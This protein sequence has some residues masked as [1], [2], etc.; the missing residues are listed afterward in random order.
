MLDIKF[1][2][3]NLDAVKA[4][5]VARKVNPE[6]AEE[7][8]GC[9]KALQVSKKEVEHF[10]E[11]RNKIA[12]EMSKG[13]PDDERRRIL[14]EEGKK[15][16]GL[17][18]NLE[19]L[20]AE[21]EEQMKEVL[22]QIPNMALGAPNQSVILRTSGKIP[23]F[24]FE[25]LDHVQLAEKLDLIDFEAGADVVGN[26]FYYLKNDLVF[27]EMA[28]ITYA[29]WKLTEKGFTPIITPDLAKA[30]VVEGIGFNP[31]G[32]NSQIYRTGDLCLIGTSEITLGGMYR[33]K[34]V[35]EAS[36]P[37]KLAGFSHCFRTEAG[38]PGKE[39][40][41]IFRV[42]QFSKVEMFI[43]CRP[44][45]SDKYHQ[46]LLNIEEEIFKDFELPFQVTDIP[47]DDLGAPAA[48]K[49][50]IEAW[51]PGRKDYCEVTSTSNCT[52]FQARR[53]N[54]KCR[55]GKDKARYLHTLNGTAVATSRA[56]IAILE[57]NQQSDGSVR[58][59]EVLRKYMRKNY[60]SRF[61]RGAKCASQGKL[62]P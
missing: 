13:N 34:V 25:P 62:S 14:I 30:E 49:Y 16:K 12:N 32:E 44:E 57:N 6:F 41:G 11:E 24:P 46:E 37:I 9:Y 52:D 4:N 31:R 26:K 53:L 20:T 5:C 18:A 1:V 50:D 45:D 8:V 59:P 29:M 17:V 27:L 2:K 48:R 7:A 19:A 60:I 54:I 47:I 28:L 51:M 23:E 33:N 15:I 35:N 42:H 22:F 56:M 40:K 58:I 3:E 36:L 61:H 55:A 39:G 21:L 43:F 10:N 38:A